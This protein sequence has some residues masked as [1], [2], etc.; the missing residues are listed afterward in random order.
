MAGAEGGEEAVR[1][2]AGAGSVG[3]VGEVRVWARRDGGAPG[4]YDA[5]GGRHGRLRVL[6]RVKGRGVCVRSMARRDVCAARERGGHALD[7]IV[8]RLALRA[9]C[10]GWQH[11]RRRDLRVRRRRTPRTGLLPDARVRLGHGR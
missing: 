11:P 9:V 7:P 3:G 2:E 4:G 8:L 1:V 5:A 10:S 6:S